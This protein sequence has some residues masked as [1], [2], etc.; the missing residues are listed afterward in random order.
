[1]VTHTTSKRILIYIVHI[2]IVTAA[3][4]FRV[5]TINT[6]S[7]TERSI[8]DL[9]AQIITIEGENQKLHTQIASRSIPQHIIPQATHIGLRKAPLSKTGVPTE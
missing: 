2:G 6:T 4:V 7:E 5:W 9:H 3:M 1:M 8:S